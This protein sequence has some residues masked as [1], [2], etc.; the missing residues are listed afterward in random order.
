[1]AGTLRINDN[2]VW[3]PAGWIYDGVLELIATE[4][5][6][7]DRILAEALREARTEAKGY[8]DLRTLDNARFLLVL[9]ATE[10]V[11][12]RTA[13]QG[14]QSF[15]DPSFYPGFIKHFDKLRTLLKTDARAA[16]TR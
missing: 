8:H 12:A 16:G 3:M 7:Q 1:M 4:L 11:F 5:A 9:N 10:R 2:A 14:A 6:N 15:N 13:S